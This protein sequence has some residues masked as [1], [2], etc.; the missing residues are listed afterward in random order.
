MMPKI[1]LLFLIIFITYLIYYRL[2]FIRYPKDLLEYK[3][4]A[5]HYDK[6]FILFFTLF[7]LILFLYFLYK[8]LNTNLLKTSNVNFFKKIS[9]IYYIKLLVTFL[10]ENILQ[11]PSKVYYYVYEKFYLKTYIEYI[12]RHLHLW[13]FEKPEHF[14]LL[15]LALPLII[16][17]SVFAFE[18][19]VFFRIKYFYKLLWLLLI[20]LVARVIIYIIKHHAKSCLDYFK[21]F[22]VFKV[23]LSNVKRL[24]DAVVHITYKKLQDPLQIEEQN[25]FDIND[26]R[27]WWEFYQYLYNICYQIDKLNLKYK[28]LLYMLNYAL[29][30]IGFF[31]WLLI[32]TNYI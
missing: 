3:L 6:I 13:F 23:N 28:Y 29:Y 4:S 27:I 7:F 14:Y 9:N 24:E 22:F 25:Q 26:L 18:I 16:C 19:I 15:F 21:T 12:G 5:T 20:P 1:S 17:S 30:F 32:I 2:I 8:T 31:C 10:V 11:G